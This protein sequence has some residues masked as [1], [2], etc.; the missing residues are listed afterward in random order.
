MDSGQHPKRPERRSLSRGAFARPNYQLLK[1]EILKRCRRR[2]CRRPPGRITGGQRTEGSN[3]KAALAQFAEWSERMSDMEG[4]SR[5]GEVT[6][7]GARERGQ[8]RVS[9]RFGSEAVGYWHVAE[10]AGLVQIEPCRCQFRVFIL[11]WR[12]ATRNTASE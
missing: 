5:T 7:V 11:G 6:R 8:E 4:P 1:A 10:F 9:N 2:N 12:C 3:L